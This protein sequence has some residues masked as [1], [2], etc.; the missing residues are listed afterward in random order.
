MA[1]GVAQLV[2]H[3]VRDVGV[4]RSSR[5]SSTTKAPFEVL[6]LLEIDSDE[7]AIIVVKWLFHYYSH[8]II[9][10][11]ITEDEELVFADNLLA[12]GHWRW[13][14]GVLYWRCGFSSKLA[15]V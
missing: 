11:S 13:G 5:L 3:H 2:A 1:R 7:N 10:I 8:Y 15:S 6:L 12:I 14:M 9:G 4:G